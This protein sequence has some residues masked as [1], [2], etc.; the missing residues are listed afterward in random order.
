MSD[1][2]EVMRVAEGDD[3][4]AVCQGTL[5]P[6]LHGLSPD[7]LSVASMAIEAQQWPRVELD[8]DVLIAKERALAQRVDV[9][10]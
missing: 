6:V 4:H 7:D 2:P 8:A 3:A 9:A 10:G 1:T 5:A